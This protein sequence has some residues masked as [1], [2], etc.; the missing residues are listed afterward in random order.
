MTYAEI[1]EIRIMKKEDSKEEYTL[2]SENILNNIK[3]ESM[4]NEKS[5]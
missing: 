5:P 3:N 4:N 2:V 1:K